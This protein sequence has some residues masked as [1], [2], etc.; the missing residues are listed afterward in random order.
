MAT[1]HP[2]GT[3]TL[4]RLFAAQGHWEQSAAIYRNLLRENPDRQDLAQA[5][6]EAEAAMQ[7]AG[8]AS[9][10]ALGPL[11]QKWIDL[12]FAYD[13]VRKLRRLKARL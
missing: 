1:D 10:E 3:V 6:V 9:P 13:R 12:L 4:A 5:L 8:P 11:L 2:H 7:A